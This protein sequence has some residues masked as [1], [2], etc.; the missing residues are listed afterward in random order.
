VKPF[1]RRKYR[2]DSFIR[3]LIEFIGEHNHFATTTV[4]KIDS[5]DRL[6][7]NVVMVRNPILFFSLMK[8]VSVSIVVSFVNAPLIEVCDVE[9]ID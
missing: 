3:Q 4:V 6:V 8:A 9:M 2:R 7:Y 1:H 5:V